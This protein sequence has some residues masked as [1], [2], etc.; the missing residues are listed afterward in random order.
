MIFSIALAKSLPLFAATWPT[1]SSELIIR[2]SPTALVS[3]A[4][5]GV[6]LASDSSADKQKVSI[7]P[8][9]MEISADAT[10][11]ARYFLSEIYPR[12]VTGISRD[13]S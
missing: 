10:T 5:T 6:P 4:T 1:K 2:N 7:G 9:A 11:D 13:E 8:G 12:K 3:D